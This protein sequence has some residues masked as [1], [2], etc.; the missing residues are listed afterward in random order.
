MKIQHIS[1]TT[2]AG[3]IVVPDECYVVGIELNDITGDA[4]LMAYNALTATAAQLFCTLR[5]CDEQQSVNIMFP[6]PGLKCDA[7][8]VNLNG[9]DEVGTLYYYY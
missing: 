7:V 9:T 2:S 1:I 4:Y 3:L 6:M 5:A 8:Y